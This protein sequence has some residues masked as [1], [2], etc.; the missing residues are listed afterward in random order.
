MGQESRPKDHIR[1]AFWDDEDMR[2]LIELFVSELG[3]RID[4]LT[5]AWERGHADQIRQVAHQL[6]GASVGYGFESI[7]EAAES[8]ELSIRALSNPE[9]LSSTEGAFR[10]LIDL[11]RRAMAGSSP[12]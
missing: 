7:G 4:D 5:V 2:D 9:D 1:S 3:T 11:C 12:H 10:D 8:L 6:S